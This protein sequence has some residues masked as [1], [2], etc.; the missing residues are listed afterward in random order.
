MSNKLVIVKSVK[1]GSIAEQSGMQDGDVI[2]SYGGVRI[3][4][5]DDLRH[6]TGFN[7]LKMEPIEVA[8]HPLGN[9]EDIRTLECRPGTLGAVVGVWDAETGQEVEGTHADISSSQV[10]RSLSNPL[11]AFVKLCAYLLGGLGVVCGI[12]IIADMGFVDQLYSTESE[13]QPFWIAVGVGVIL[14]S[15]FFAAFSLVSIMTWENTDVL[16]REFLEKK[17]TSHSE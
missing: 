12:W 8:V 2:V 11:P 1:D 3:S 7:R 15:V 6:A 16:R 13:P 17:I 14:Q 9:P 5:I 4:S 10:D